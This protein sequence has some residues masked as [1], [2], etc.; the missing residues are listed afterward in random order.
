MSILLPSPPDMT[1]DQ[2]EARIRFHE[3]TAEMFKERDL[4][5]MAKKFSELAAVY[6]TE[7]ERRFQR[8]RKPVNERMI[9]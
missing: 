6:R 5:N 8:M 4:L 2:L 9:L 1:I 3:S 7:L